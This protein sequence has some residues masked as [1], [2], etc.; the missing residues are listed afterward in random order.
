M[1]VK[2]I[3]ISLIMLLTACI[4][5]SLAQAEVGVTKGKIVVGAIMNLTGPGAYGGNEITRGIATYFK[6]TNDKGGV[7]GRKIKFIV[8]DNSYQVAKTLAAYKKL[9]SKDRMFCMVGNIGSS[10]VEAL[11][12]LLKKDKIPLI[13]AISVHTHDAIPRY[14]FPAY[15][16]YGF[17]SKL[18]VDYI[19]GTLGDRK[20]KIGVLRNKT[21]FGLRGL[22]GVIEQVKNYGG[23]E[24]VDVSFPPGAADVSAQVLKLKEAGVDY[25][26][27]AGLMR[28]IASALMEARKIGWKPHWFALNPGLSEH[29]IK[30]S[31]GAAEYGHGLKGT[32]NYSLIS[33]SQVSRE[34]LANLKKYYPDK[35]PT[36]YAFGM[37]YG[38]G[39][40][41][42][43]ALKRAGK[44]LTRENIIRALET[45]KD[46]D[47]GC[48]P[49]QTFG[50]GD[51]NPSKKAF[52]AK[53]EN[54][55]LIRMTDWLEPKF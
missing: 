10:Q 34:F 4:T 12:P 49:P 9:K 44:D 2:N 28:A 24:P 48:L 26:V 42:V 11:F 36:V 20:P 17:Q 39:D 13:G 16:P 43:E 37:G 40:M 47:N 14:A 38:A 50:P 6:A 25:V 53:A 21:D 54:G 18:I 32:L 23:P 3:T 51:R 19:V 45:F 22:E 52:F 1:K 29:V 33:D 55:K 30:I 27:Y 15:T 7:Y 5:F 35:K 41:F 8:E 31:Q 46:Y